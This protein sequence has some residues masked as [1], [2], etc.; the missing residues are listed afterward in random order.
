MKRSKKVMFVLIALTLVCTIMSTSGL[1]SVIEN[2]LSRIALS[3]EKSDFIRMTIRGRIKD[4]EKDDGVV[5]FVAI[6]VVITMTC[7]VNG[8][9]QNFRFVLKEGDG[10]QMWP[11]YDF[12]GLCGPNYI[13]GFNYWDLDFPQENQSFL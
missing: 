5:Y 1:S 9:R 10:R 4:L 8:T 7:C 2:D 13:L 11:L 12:V 6:R 3:K